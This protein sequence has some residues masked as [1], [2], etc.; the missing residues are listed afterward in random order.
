VLRGLIR[1][2]A[3]ED[4]Q[5]LLGTDQRDRRVGVTHVAGH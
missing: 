1:T 2:L 5:K 3:M 4:C